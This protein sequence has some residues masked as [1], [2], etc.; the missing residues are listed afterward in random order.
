VTAFE[1]ESMAKIR[2]PR[3][4]ISRYRSTYFNH[5]WNSGYASGYYSYVWC[6]V[7]DADAFQAFKEKGNLFDPATALSFRKNVLEKGGSE[8]PMTLYTRFR[9]REPRVDALLLRLGFKKATTN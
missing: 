7:L 2:L 3:E 8:D 4:I 1:Q 5:I 6:Q 9:G